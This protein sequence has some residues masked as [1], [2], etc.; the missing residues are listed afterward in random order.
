[1]N[2]PENVG[3][4]IR[5]ALYYHPV[6]NFYSIEEFQ[7]KGYY[8]EHQIRMS[9]IFDLTI[10][11]PTKDDYPAI[12]AALENQKR[13]VEDTER[14]EKLEAMQKA[15]NAK[16]YIE[17]LRCR[18]L[19]LPAPTPLTIYKDGSIEGSFDDLPF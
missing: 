3:K 1:M 14:K 2:Y 7:E 18:L 6:I 8:E 16:H 12:L 5:A 9:A 4:T 10:P 11:P 19:Q 15:A 13:A 17:V